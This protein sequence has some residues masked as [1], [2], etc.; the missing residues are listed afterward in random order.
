MNEISLDDWERWRFYASQSNF[1]VH[2]L[3]AL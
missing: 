3:N 1:R 2:S